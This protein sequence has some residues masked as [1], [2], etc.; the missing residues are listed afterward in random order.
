MSKNFHG[1]DFIENDVKQWSVKD[2]LKFL[3]KIGMKNYNHS[4]YKNKIKG[5]DLLSLTEKEL[6]SDL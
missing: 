2:V 1:C 4:F 6:K 3:T 5:K